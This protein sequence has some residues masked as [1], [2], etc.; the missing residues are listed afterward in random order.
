[1]LKKILLV[2]LLFTV[3]SSCK[4]DDGTSQTTCEKVGH[5][6][7]KYKAVGDENVTHMHRFCRRAFCD[8]NETKSLIDLSNK[9]NLEQWN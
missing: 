2:I 7:S 8:G 1:M 9:N 6:W 5:F 3:V 4:Q